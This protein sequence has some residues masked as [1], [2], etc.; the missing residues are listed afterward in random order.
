M[1]RLLEEIEDGPGR[2]IGWMHGFIWRK[3]KLFEYDKYKE[4]WH[5]DGPSMFPEIL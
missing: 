1:F 5:G 2:K 3:N 4:V